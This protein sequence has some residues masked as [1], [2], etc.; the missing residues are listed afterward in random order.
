[1]RRSFNS[2]KRSLPLQ[3][4]RREK[5]NESLCVMGVSV[6]GRYV[7]PGKTSVPVHVVG[8]SGLFDVGRDGAESLGRR[9]KDPCR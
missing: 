8:S 1:M 9:P 3:F 5:C 7:S 6:Y 2:G 4:L